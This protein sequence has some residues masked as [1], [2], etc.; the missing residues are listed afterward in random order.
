M[1]VVV[2]E[3]T[4]ET[5]AVLRISRLYDEE[6]YFACFRVY[7]GNK[8]NGDTYSFELS[9]EQPTIYSAVWQFT[10]ELKKIMG[11]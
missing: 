4:H 11:V 3:A 2:I 7:R 6:G 1:E 9:G 8:T 5:G 10:E